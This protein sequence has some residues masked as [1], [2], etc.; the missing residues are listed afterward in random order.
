MN[1]FLFFWQRIAQENLFKTKHRMCRLPVAKKRE[2]AEKQI[3]KMKKTQPNLV[4]VRIT[5]KAIATTWWGKAWNSNLENY[6]DFSSGMPRGAVMY[7]MV[8]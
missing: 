8:W 3:A 6:S 7:V 1:I 4:P 5:G 2:N